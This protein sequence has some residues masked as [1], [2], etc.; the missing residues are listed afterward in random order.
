VTA[1]VGLNREIL[2]P[3]TAALDVGPPSNASLLTEND[4]SELRITMH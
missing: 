1:Q 4:D 2:S 3:R